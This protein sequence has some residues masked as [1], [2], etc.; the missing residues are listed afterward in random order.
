MH[1][2]DEVSLGFKALSVHPDFKDSCVFFSI[3]NPSREI[4]IGVKHELLPTISVVLR[5]DPNEELD[6][7]EQFTVD[8]SQPF[9][10]LLKTMKEKLGHE[11]KAEDPV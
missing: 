6:N 2:N 4:F 3:E 11:I 8:A 10:V 7:V 5:Q 9:Q 1:K